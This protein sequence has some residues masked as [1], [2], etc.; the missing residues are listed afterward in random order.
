M[1][2][3]FL[4]KCHLYQH[5]KREVSRSQRNKQLLWQKIL[6]KTNLKNKYQFKRNNQV[7]LL[8]C[9]FQKRKRTSSILINFRNSNRSLALKVFIKKHSHRY[10]SDVVVNVISK[11]IWV[12]VQIV[13]LSFKLF[14]HKNSILKQSYKK[15]YPITKINHK[16][17]LCHTVKTPEFLKFLNKDRKSV[18]PT[19]SLWNT[20]MYS[21]C[22]VIP[23]L[24]YM[25]I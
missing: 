5:R 17:N 14:F 25:K 22:L 20:E 11:K 13:K 6:N 8:L 10:A 2:Q 21:N 15:D 1:D 7:C 9:Q 3:K 18:N 16:K 24:K 12:S 4:E 23:Q 19:H